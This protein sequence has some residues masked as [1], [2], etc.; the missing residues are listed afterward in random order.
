M[1]RYTVTARAPGSCG[2]LIQGALAGVDLQLSCPIDVAAE[3]QLA[4]GGQVPLLEGLPR[5]P[6]VRAAIHAFLGHEGAG[7]MGRLRLSNPLP[8]GKG[9]GT[10]TA[11]IAAAL[12]ALAAGL[13]RPVTPVDLARAALTVEPSDGTLFPGIALFDHRRGQVHGSLGDPP[14]LEVLIYDTGGTVNTARFNDRPDLARRNQAKEPMVRE[15]L[16]LAW[17]GLRRGDVEA[18]GAAATLSARAHQALLPKACLEPVLALAREVG[19]VGVNVAH[20]GTLLGILLDPRRTPAAEAQP[21]L[22]A[23]LGST[24]RAARVVG[25]GVSVQVKA[26]GEGQAGDGRAVGA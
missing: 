7:V 4:F 21:F 9:F 6:K 24:L 14:P 18:I 8:R 16:A 12:S 3:A 17:E 26:D 10:S 23:R 20:S 22:E 5:H 11:D 25:G 2:E 15:A 1:L 19:A 13:S